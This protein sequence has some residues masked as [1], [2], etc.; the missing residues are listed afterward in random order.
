MTAPLTPAEQSALDVV[1]RTMGHRW[2][3]ALRRWWEHCDYPS[4]VDAQALQGLRNMRGPV[5]LD[6]YRHQLRLPRS[7]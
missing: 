3:S 2:K 4:W 5:W 7:K 6:R 1:V